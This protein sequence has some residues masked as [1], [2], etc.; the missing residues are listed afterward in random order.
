MTGTNTAILSID[1]MVP[2]TYEFE[3][4]VTDDDGDTDTDLVTVNVLPAT[5]NTAPVATASADINV[6]LPTNSTKV[7]GS[8]SDDGPSVTVSWQKISGPSVNLAGI[9]S[10]TL[11]LTNLV[12]GTY[13]FRYTVDDGT[14]TDFD[15]VTVNVFAAPVQNPLPTVEAGESI[16]LPY[17]ENTVSVIAVANAP[18][19]LITSYKWSLISGEPVTIEPDTTSALTVVGLQPGIY[20]FRVTVIDGVGQEA[21]DDVEVTVMGPEAQPSNMFSPNGDT[22]DPTWRIQSPLLLEGCDII[23]Y[24]RQGQKVYESIGYATEWDGVFNGKPLPEGVYFYVI[25]CDGAKAQTGSVT[26]IR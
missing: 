15:D 13:V 9:N 5:I 1:G 10:D 25:R 21:S 19:G 16:V 23:V 24:N 2:G 22:T 6:V 4:T 14:L 26:L 3:L 12:E 18:D 8:W 11:L 7:G 20:T 17:P